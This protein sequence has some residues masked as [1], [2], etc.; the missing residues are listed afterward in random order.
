[1][2]PRAQ[3]CEQRE[4]G[5]GIIETEEEEKKK[6]KNPAS[7]RDISRPAHL[8]S[9]TNGYNAMFYFLVTWLKCGS[10]LFET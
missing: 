2:A 10:F 8:Q 3:F 1:M 7:R 4:G 9:M 6:E 5:K